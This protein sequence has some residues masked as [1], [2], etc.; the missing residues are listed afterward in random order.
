EISGVVGAGGMGEGYRARDTRL[1]RDVAI[2]VLPSRIARDPLAPERFDP[3]ARTIASVS[4]PRICTVFDVGEH[5]GSPYLV[6]ELL[7]GQ[8]LYATLQ[9]GGLPVDQVIEWGI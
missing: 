6:L 8:P 5:E 4:H 3:E 1:D 9:P 7:E 2:K